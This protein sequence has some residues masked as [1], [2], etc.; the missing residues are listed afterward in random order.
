MK[1]KVLQ[2]R[3][4]LLLTLVCVV[5]FSCESGQKRPAKNMLIYTKTGE[6]YVHKNIA[7][8]VKA[9][10]EICEREG[11]QTEVTNDPAKFTPENLEKYDAIFFANTA[12]N[13]FDSQAQKD[14]FQAFCRSGKGFGG[15]HAANTTERDWPWFVQLIGGKFVRH[16][17]YQAFDVLVV[18]PNH[19]STR[20]LPQRWT[21]ADECYISDQLNPDIQILMVADLT[22]VS[23]P[24]KDEYPGNT[25]YNSFP[26]VWCHEFEGGRQWFS[27]LG[28][29]PEFYDDPL[30]REHIRGGIRWILS[31]E[32]KN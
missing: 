29:D 20:P 14:A 1:M 25:F 15:V 28:H 5:L 7:N 16:P 12:N 2:R 19:P 9:I 13:V 18:D 30:F 10:R 6:G 11:I 17:V 27:A 3:S 4:L 22:T 8:S 24:L 21:I 31:L 23:D 32:Q 26:L